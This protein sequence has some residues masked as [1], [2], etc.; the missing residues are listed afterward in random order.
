M[1]GV[2]TIT[3]DSQVNLTDSSVKGCAMAKL[4]LSYIEEMG[5]W[6]RCRVGASAPSGA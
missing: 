5:L 6:T 3:G 1:E 2:D 4:I